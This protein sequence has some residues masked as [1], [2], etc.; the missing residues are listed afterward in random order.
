MVDYSCDTCINQYLNQY[1]DKC[2]H[3]MVEEYHGQR[4]GTPTNYEQIHDD[5]D[6]D[7]AISRKKAIKIAK[8]ISKKAIPKYLE[9][10]PSVYP[11]RK[12]YWIDKSSSYLNRFLTCSECSYTHGFLADFKHCPYCGVKMNG[13][14][15]GIE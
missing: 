11:V 12:G 5:D 9:K 10:L 3:C 13:Y 7:D 15:R 4:T 6:D 2:N 8:C 14:K 1:A